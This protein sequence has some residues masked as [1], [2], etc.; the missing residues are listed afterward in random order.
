MASSS[1][2]VSR[3]IYLTTRTRSQFVEDMQSCLAKAL[4]PIEV[5]GSALS[6]GEESR[7]PPVEESDD[8]TEEEIAAARERRAAKPYSWFKKKGRRYTVH[9]LDT[10]DEMA[11]ARSAQLLGAA[12]P[13]RPT[14]HGGVV[15]TPE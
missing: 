7:P 3:S 10:R 8:M 4:L 2:G 6:G 5:V 12:L 1:N 9:N 15:S 11:Y 13:A 14:L